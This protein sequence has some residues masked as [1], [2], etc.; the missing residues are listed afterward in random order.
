MADIERSKAWLDSRM[1]ELT[2][3]LLA[4]K[5]EVAADEELIAGLRAWQAEFTNLDDQPDMG[6]DAT[7]ATAATAATTITGGDPAAAAGAGANQS[8]GEHSTNTE[9]LPKLNLTDQSVTEAVRT[10]AE[11]LV[12]IITPIWAA[13]KDAGELLSRHYESHTKGAQ[14]HQFEQRAQELFTSKMGNIERDMGELEKK[15]SEVSIE[16]ASLQDFLK[17]V[18]VSAEVQVRWGEVVTEIVKN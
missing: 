15:L 17:L 7:A 18:E 2:E 10:L 16:D 14:L 11:T 8:Q 6:E 13:S 1:T 4:L 9:K 5:T 3:K 12:K